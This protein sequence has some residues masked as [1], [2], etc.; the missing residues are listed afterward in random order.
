[1][2]LFWIIFGMLI[3]GW[4]WS[5]VVNWIRIRMAYRIL[6]M[7]AP[8]HRQ[9][10]KWMQKDAKLIMIWMVLSILLI[11][12]PIQYRTGALT[13][14]VVSEIRTRTAWLILPMFVLRLRPTLR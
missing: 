5:E 4:I 12:A 10:L 14:A 9:A 11:N 6:L 7:S 13:T 8:L 2:T 3:V 1:M